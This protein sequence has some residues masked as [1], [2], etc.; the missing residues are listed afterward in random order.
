MDLNA[1][2]LRFAA[3]RIARYS[4]QT[5]RRNVLEPIAF[6]APKFDSVGVN[7]L[8]ALP[9]RRDR[10]KGHRLRSSEGR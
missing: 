9:A 1:N 4:P 7:Y 6:D 2:A 10:G 5:Y 8:L 3:D